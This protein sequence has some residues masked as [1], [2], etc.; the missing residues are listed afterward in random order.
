MDAGSNDQSLQTAWESLSHGR[1]ADGHGAVY[2]F[3]SP[4]SNV[5]T[6]YVTRNMALLVAAQ[7]PP[8]KQVLIV[9]MDIQ[10]SAQANWF[11]AQ[12]A[13]TK[14]GSPDGP[15]DAS[16]GMQSFWRVTPSMVGKDGQNLTDSHFMSLHVVNSANVAFTCF[17]W[18]QFR[19]GQTV[20]MQNA[21]GYWLKLRENFA[22]IFVDTPAL[23][24]AD[25][26]GAICPLADSTV[27][28]CAPGEA[29]SKA[30][31][32]AYT[33]ISAMPSQCAGVILNDLPPQYSGYGGSI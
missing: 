19:P 27:L 22:A 17:Q 20:H 23:D 2:A 7:L 29:Q 31:G 8:G 33:K 14:Y 6:S 12:Q 30:L 1:R 15:Y 9:D 16:F 13:V 3:A 21:H 10:S 24:R 25:I 4:T 26:L 5:G 28:V 32:D 11:F 18:Q